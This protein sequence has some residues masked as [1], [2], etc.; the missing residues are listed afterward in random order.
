M[1][2]KLSNLL[3][4]TNWSFVPTWTHGIIH[5]HSSQ[6]FGDT[7]NNNTLSFIQNLK[8]KES[9][10]EINM[11]NYDE[12]NKYQWNFDGLPPMVLVPH[13]VMNYETTY[14]NIVT[15][16]CFFN[17]NS[18]HITEKSFVPFYFYQLPI[19]VA[20]HNHVKMMKDIYG[21]DFFDDL[22]NHNYDNEKNDFKRINMIFEEIKRLHDN[23]DVVKE[24]YKNNQI[25]FENNRQLVLNNI[26]YDGDYLF[27]KN[28]L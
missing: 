4:D 17:S 28:L 24:F 20:T 1:Y 18:I 11:G 6:V 27:F 2:L 25:R 10:F 5:E 26:T 7:I 9:E 13:R 19:I 16:S 3:E 22:I 14:V 8:Y 12:E 23:K 15:E 21:F